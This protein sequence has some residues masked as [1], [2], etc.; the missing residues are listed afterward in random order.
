M[1]IWPQIF[2]RCST[3]DQEISYTDHAIGELLEG[4]T[5][6]GRD[7]PLIVFSADHG[8]NIGDWDLYFEHGPN[9]H[10]ASFRVP[11]IFAGPQVSVGRSDIAAR[12]QDIAPTIESLL[13]LPKSEE[14]HYDGLDLSPAWKGGGP[15]PQIALGE[16]GSAL[17]ARLG[18]YLVTGRKNDFDVSTIMFFFMSRQKN[19][20]S[21]F[22]RS[23]DPFLKNVISLHSE[24]AEI[25]RRAWEKWPVERTV[26]G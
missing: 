4:L 12:L 24:Q 8:E 23:S 2:K 20:E 16:S 18:D 1:T 21:L 14:R 26:N 9:V 25:L 19:E 10:D 17:H 15:L 13:Q 5:L 7:N 11:L 22:D 3:F 6:R